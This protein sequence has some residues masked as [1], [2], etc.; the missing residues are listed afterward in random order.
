MKV[1][2]LDQHENITEIKEEPKKPKSNSSVPG[3]CV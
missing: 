1:V 2:D 3:L